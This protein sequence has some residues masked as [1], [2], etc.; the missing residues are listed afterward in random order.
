M[1]EKIEY[2]SISNKGST[3][4]IS[5]KGGVVTSWTV[6]SGEVAFDVIDGY[7]TD[8]E[9]TEGNGARSAILAPWSNRIRDSRYQWNG[10]SYDLGPDEDG[11]RD[12][13]HG[14]FVGRDFQLIEAGPNWALLQSEVGADELGESY[15]EGKLAYPA[16]LKVTVRY[17]LDFLQQ[18]WQL[19]I[20]VNVQNLGSEV[21]PIALGWHPYIRY[22]GPRAQSSITMRART[23]VRID[24]GKIPLDGP[25][26]FEPAEGWDEES[27]VL[28]LSA[29]QDLD[30]AYTDL[31]TT[32]GVE[33][34][35]SAFLNH[36]SGATT[37]VRASVAGSGKRG[38]GVF[39][40]FT[41]EGLAHRVRESVAIEFCRFMPNI[42]NRPEFAQEISVE[43]NKSR[44]MDVY[45]IHTPPQK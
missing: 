14:L 23:Q 16:A 29:P 42:M 25:E 3:A 7:A 10:V 38:S 43:P 32:T 28:T 35:S 5:L 6:P 26:A 2:H 18:R 11:V 33:A 17:Q 45:L 39:H 24:E 8:E 30:R 40:V 22:D 4:T 37:E 41:G 21:A 19:G 31:T 27:G 44:T 36:A 13:L 12:G 20:R 9:V 1:A 15:E 34:T